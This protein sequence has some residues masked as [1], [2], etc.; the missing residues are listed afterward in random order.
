MVTSA[1]T[2]WSR[3]ECLSSN[4]DSPSQWAREFTQNVDCRAGPTVSVVHPPAKEATHMMNETQPQHTRIH[5]PALGITPPN[6]RNKSGHDERHQQDEPQVIP[7]L[8]PNNGVLVE[9]TNI[10]D[11]RFSAGLDDHPADMGPEEAAVCVVGVEFGIGV[12]VVCA[13]AAGPPFDGAFDCAS[14]S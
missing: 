11:P 6:P 12:S 2:R 13:V 3:G 5:V 7:V 1:V 9:I 10:G 4:G 8:P 14:A